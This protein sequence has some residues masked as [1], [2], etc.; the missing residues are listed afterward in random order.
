MTV[1]LTSSSPN[2]RP[3]TSAAR[4]RNPSNPVEPKQ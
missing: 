4:N 2:P 1:L 3:G